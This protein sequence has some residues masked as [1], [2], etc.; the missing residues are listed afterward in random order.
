MH[1]IPLS[2][3]IISPNESMIDNLI[4]FQL[5]ILNIDDINLPVCEKHFYA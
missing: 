1:H 5:K 3:I 4:I 2:T